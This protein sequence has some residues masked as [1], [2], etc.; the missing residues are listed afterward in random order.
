MSFLSGLGNLA[1][2]VL[3]AIP[4]IGTVGSAIAS[5]L[6]VLGSEFGKE[7]AMD[8]QREMMQ[9]NHSRRYG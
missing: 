5:G 2:G 8:F 1:S 7:E 9:Q 4:G 6:G 3:G